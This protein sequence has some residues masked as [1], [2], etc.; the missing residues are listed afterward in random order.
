[1]ICS[2]F[3]FFFSALLPPPNMYDRISNVIS[4]DIGYRWK[5]FARGLKIREAEIDNLE[6]KYRDISDRMREVLIDFTHSCPEHYYRTRIVEALHEARRRDLARA[7]ADIIDHNNL[8]LC[9]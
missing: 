4:R 7:V 2:N 8:R 3:Q 1:M 5:D 9:A 6:S